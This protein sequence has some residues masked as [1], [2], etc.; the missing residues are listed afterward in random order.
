MDKKFFEHM[1]AACRL[2]QE[3]LRIKII[4]Q[5]G[6]IAICEMMIKKLEEAK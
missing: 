4:R 3:E 6:A 5:D 1:I 2:E